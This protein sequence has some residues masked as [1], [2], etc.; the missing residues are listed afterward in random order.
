MFK[1]REKKV[2]EDF[3]YDFLSGTRYGIIGVSGSGKTT[4]ASILAGYDR[5]DAGSIVYAKRKSD[6]SSISVRN[7]F[8]DTYRFLNPVNTLEWYEK[9]VS[10]IS[11]DPKLIDKVLDAVGLPMDSFGSRY[12]DQLSGGQRQRLA[13]AMVLSQLPDV[14]I[15]DEPFS[16]IDPPNAMVLFSLIRKY[17]DKSTVIYIDHNIDRVA[18]LCDHIIAFDKGR[19][20]E[21][22]DVERIFESPKTEYVEKLIRASEKISSRMGR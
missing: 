16:M 18:Y 10:A 7:V 1:W 20:V 4:L 6:G 5:P 21:E 11:P 22:G 3:S 2:I 9:N 19:I 13:F 12:I 15:L 17:L 14:L 8:Q